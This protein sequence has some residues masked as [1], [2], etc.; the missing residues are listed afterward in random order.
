MIANLVCQVGLAT[1]LVLP[2]VLRAQER[3][4]DGARPIK[5]RV[6]VTTASIA[7]DT[8]TIAYTVENLRT[9]DEDLSEFLVGV[10]APVISM[11]APRLGHWLTEPRYDDR[12]IA[13]WAIYR[14]ARVHPGESTSEL[15][16]IARGIPDLVR[17]WATPNLMAHPADITDDPNRD[18]VFVFS[19]TGTTV[20]IVRVPASATAASLTAR[21]LELL[22]RSCGTLG[23]IDQPGVCNSIEV[24]LTHVQ[25]ALAASKAESALGELRA[26]AAELDAQHGDGPGKHVSDEAYA[27][28]RPNVT[29]LL[30]RL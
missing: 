21:L 20:G 10:S 25:D 23:W 13:E 27:L 24:K 17:Y 30:G 28:L 4:L 8:T 14:S 9:G 18:D 29:F 3:D 22:R 15:V 6:H 2:S 1:V 7:G 11:P 12:P 5:V 26:L 16:L 19:D